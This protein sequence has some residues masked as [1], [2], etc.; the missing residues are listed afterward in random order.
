MK[1]LSPITFL[2]QIKLGA[3]FAL[4]YEWSEISQSGDVSL[5]REF[6]YW[7]PR[8]DLKWDYKKNRQDQIKY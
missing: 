1:D 4:N 7:K 6:K 5:S 3:E 2:Y 8:L